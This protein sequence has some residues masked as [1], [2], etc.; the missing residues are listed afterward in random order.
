[1]TVPRLRWLLALLASL[2]VA[3][4]SGASQTSG[5]TPPGRGTPA[6]APAVPFEEVARRATAAREG[7][8]V[9]AAIRWYREAV[10]QRPSWDEGWWHLGALSYERGDS[11]QAAR[12]FSRFVRLKP[13]S[14]PGWALRG[15]A[16]FGLKNYASSMR[17]LAHGLTLGTV[18]NSEIRD[19]VYV[20]MAQLRIRA[21]QYELAVEPLSTLAHA[22]SE[23]P[24]LVATCGVF[25][26]RLPLLP[27]EVPAD[28]RPLV[29]MAGR[30][31]FSALGVKPEA[32]QRF[33]ELLASYPHTPNLHYGY[34]GYLLGQGGDHVAAALD[35]FK[36]EIEV[37]PK[38][39][40]P[41]LEIAFELFKQGQHA[42]ALPYAELAV[43][44]APGLFAA[45]AALGRAL[46]ET[47]QV[48]RGVSEL[49]EAVR[50]APESPDMRAL[51]ARA[52]F[53]AGRRE[54]AE[55]Q[56]DV[57][58]RLQVANEKMRLPGFAREDTIQ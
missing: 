20:R 6:P 19:A 40:Y 47:G 31:A 1:M 35:Q 17:Y 22:K 48:P 33:E 58:K 16:E 12:S 26:L 49:E 43:K 28:Q 24:A 39:V 14:G 18:G 37:D 10:R 15:L 55:K 13:D 53:L 34:G 57:Y 11:A 8:D 21:G 41:R 2:L 30:A 9:A 51:L 46:L 29:Q 23:T 45:H 38:A 32:P 50:L 42:E 5:T 36:K 44:L 56:R 52:Y 4:P 25:L 54:D 27:E 7:G 3:G